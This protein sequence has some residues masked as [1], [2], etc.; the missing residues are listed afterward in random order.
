MRNYTY[1][2]PAVIISTMEILKEYKT[3]H[4]DSKTPMADCCADIPAH[5]RTRF[6]RAAKRLKWDVIKYLGHIYENG[7]FVW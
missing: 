2:N 1:I 4:P 3:A 6:V 5:D 7:I